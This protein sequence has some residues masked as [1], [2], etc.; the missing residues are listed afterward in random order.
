[1]II[2]LTPL[3]PTVVDYPSLGSSFGWNCLLM[4]M[5]RPLLLKPPLVVVSSPLIDA[6][7]SSCFVVFQLL[8]SSLV[9]LSSPAVAPTS[10]CHVLSFIIFLVHF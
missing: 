3:S 10:C 6:L 1:M 4:L 5:H 8:M 2:L 7:C 9:V